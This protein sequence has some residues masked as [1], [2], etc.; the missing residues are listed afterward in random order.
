MSHTPHLIVVDVETSGLD[1]LTHDVLEV[2]AIDLTAGDE[3]HFVPTPT[4]PEWQTNAEPEA[5]RINRYYE[6]G[7]YNDQV[8]T[9][10]TGKRWKTLA[11]MLDGNIL[12]GANPQFDA[13][14]VDAAL[15]HWG[16]EPT[17]R[18]QL[19]DLATYASGILRLDPAEPISSAAIFAKLGIVNRDPH[20]ARGDATATA[21][22]FSALRQQAS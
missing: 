19:R 15:R 14:F 5:L 9:A 18:H 16:I 2:A 17:R 21:A 1:P 10:T 12:A 20:S 4:R 13:A 8:D 22:A 7:V 6:R 11:D 3:L